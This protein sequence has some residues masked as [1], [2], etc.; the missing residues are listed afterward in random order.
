MSILLHY[1]ATFGKIAHKARLKTLKTC[2]R[3]LWMTLRPVQPST[4]L[5]HSCQST[6]MYAK[7]MG[8]KRALGFFSHSI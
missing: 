8:F 2:P 6:E 1:I 7:I 4:K 3:G 5:T